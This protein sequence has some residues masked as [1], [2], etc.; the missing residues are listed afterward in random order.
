VG[1]VS[2]DIGC[3]Y[4]HLVARYCTSAAYQTLSYLAD[5]DNWQIHRDFKPSNIFLTAGGDCKIGDFGLATS[6]LAAVDPSDV[7]ASHT[8]MPDGD[9]T[10]GLQWPLSHCIFADL[11]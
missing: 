4:A 1:S 7:E 5:F 9:M 6:S 11:A 10:S 8:S 3:S 2:A